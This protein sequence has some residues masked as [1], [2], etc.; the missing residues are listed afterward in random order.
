MSKLQVFPEQMKNN[1]DL[2]KGL[3]FSQ[4]VMLAL[5]ENGGLSRQDA[6]KLVQRNAMK[7][8]KGH[9]SFLKLLSADKE[10]IAALPAKELEALFDEKYYLRYVDDIFQRLGLTEVQWQESR[11]ENHNLS[12]R[13]I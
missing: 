1:L 9:R 12:P 7:A 6:Y 3:V 4:R 11:K 8:W 5:I 13:S 10:V 2:T